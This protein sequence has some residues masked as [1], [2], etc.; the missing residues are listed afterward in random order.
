VSNIP[1]NM[2]EHVCRSLRSCPDTSLTM[3]RNSA[4]SSLHTR[5]VQAG[6]FETPLATVVAWALLGEYSS[7]YQF[8]CWRSL[9]RA[10]FETRDVC[11]EVIKNFNNTPVS[12]PGGDEHLIQ[13]RYSDTHAEYEV[14]VAQARAS[15][16]GPD[17]YLS[18]SPEDQCPVNE[19][20]LFLQGQA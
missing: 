13:I 15:S 4:P 16:A 8:C 9:S 2:N 12:K 7:H 18:M 1:K 11:E 5:S 6:F 10:S 3:R 20:E 14:G 19:F 17:H